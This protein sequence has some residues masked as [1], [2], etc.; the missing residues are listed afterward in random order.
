MDL[1]SLPA[2][3]HQ[4]LNVFSLAKQGKLQYFDYHPERE[5]DVVNFCVELIHAGLFV[6]FVC[7]VAHRPWFFSVISV[8][9]THL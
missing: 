9:I 3:R 8:L 6:Q 1:K 5:Q 2:I 7:I 4:A